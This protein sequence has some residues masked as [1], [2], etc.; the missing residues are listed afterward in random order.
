MLTLIA[1]FALT[2]VWRTRELSADLFSARMRSLN[3]SSAVFAVL[4]IAPVLSVI[5]IVKDEICAVVPDFAAVS[6]SAVLLSAV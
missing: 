2:P 3:A 4:R 1:W 5:E 6:V